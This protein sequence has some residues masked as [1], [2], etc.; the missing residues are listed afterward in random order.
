M[1]VGGV[2][3][4]DTAP[5]SVNIALNDP[6]TATDA[7]RRDHR[8][9][10]D[11]SNTG[12]LGVSRYATDAEAL[13]GTSSSRT[14][15]PANLAH[16]L[17]N[18]AGG[19]VLSDAAPA[20]VSIAAGSPG[21]ATDVSRGD[22]HHQASPAGETQ[23]GLTRYATD[24]EA[25]AATSVTR[26]INPVSLA[27]VLANTPV[28][29][30]TAEGDIAALSA[31]GV[32]ADTLIPDTIARTSTLAPITLITYLAQAYAATGADSAAISVTLTTALAD[33]YL[34]RFFYTDTNTTPDSNGYALVG[35]RR[36]ARSYR[37]SRRAAC[38]L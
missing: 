12:T 30:G 7:S 29:T 14:I 31:G 20:S 18:T 21:T 11:Q 13:L 28:T 6:G 32:W 4:S 19:V 23:F 22:H 9:R 8:H 16:V 15:N 26:T 17:A 25:L 3:L 34:L 36:P 37:A 5:V 1:Q 24:A 33:G 38:C 2:A 10:V 27:H 35:V